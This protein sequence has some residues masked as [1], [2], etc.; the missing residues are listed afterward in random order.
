MYRILIIILICSEVFKALNK[1]RGLYLRWQEI[2]KVPA[3]HPPNS[4]EVEWTSTE[5]RNALRSIEWDLE[6]LEDT[7]NIL[8]IGLHF[9]LFS[10]KL[11]WWWWG[12]LQCFNLYENT[13]N[14]RVITTN[15][16]R[17]GS[18]SL[19]F[20]TVRFQTVV[21]NNGIY[22]LCIKHIRR[23]TYCTTWTLCKECLQLKMQLGL[24]VIYK[25][26]QNK[27]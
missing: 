26:T 16:C 24:A 15:I 13:L 3:V 1:T 23:G 19:V 27:R 2:S 10:L 22:S 8:F 11:K 21:T 18:H 4:P 25:R 17:R 20:Y 6:D 5:L 14:D 12:F 9:I 7:I